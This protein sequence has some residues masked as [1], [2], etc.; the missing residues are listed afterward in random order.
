MVAWT[1][2]FHPFANHATIVAAIAVK[3]Y[4]PNSLKMY[5]ICCMKVKLDAYC[6]REMVGSWSVSLVGYLMVGW[7]KV[8]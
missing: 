2:G 3:I 7:L 4:P 8:K 5:S 6:V 1:R